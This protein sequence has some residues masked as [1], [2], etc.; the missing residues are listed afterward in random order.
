MGIIYAVIFKMLRSQNL[1]FPISLRSWVYF[2][3]RTFSCRIG[4]QPA[5][6]DVEPKNL[7][8]TTVSPLTF[9]SMIF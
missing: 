6:A 2:L 3:V 9:V 8:H 5:I 1:R 4:D 7:E